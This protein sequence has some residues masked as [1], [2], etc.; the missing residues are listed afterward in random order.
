M[1]LT[2]ETYYNIAEKRDRLRGIYDEYG[3]NAVFIVPAGL[4]KDALLDLICGGTPYFGER[5]LVWTV[6][7]LYK[8]LTRSS[9]SRL[10]VI[11]PPDH[12]LILRWLLDGFLAEMGELGVKL[13]PGVYHKGFVSVLGDNIKDLLAEEVSSGKLSA[14]LFEEGEADPALP[15][16]ILISLYERYTDYLEE[17]GLAD[18][19]QLPTLAR[20]AIDSARALDFIKDKKIVLAG[21][22]SFTGAQLKLARALS[23]A[24]EVLMLQPETGLDDFHDGIKQLETEY[25]ERP[26][27]D[28]PVV[29]LEASNAHL[30]LEMLARDVALWINGEGGLTALGALDDYGDVGLLTLP[31]RLPVME[32]ALSR[33]KIPYNVR[34]RGTVRETPAGELPAMI[35]RAWSS[36][37]DYYNTSILLADPLLFD[38][39]EEGAELYKAD[40]FPEGYEA[41]RRA[42][43]PRA[44]GR[45]AD[46]RELCRSFERGG[47]PVEI[48]AFWRDFLKKA[49][50]VE[51]AARTAGGEASLD[52]MVRNISHALFELEKKI[53]ILSD[54]AKH[55]GPASGAALR[56]AEAV[57]FVSDWGETATLP[58][59][60][61]QSHSLTLYAGMPPILTSHRFWLM[62]DIDYNSWPGMLRESLLLRNENKV[63]FNAG[64]GE[65]GERP[66]LPE[67]REERE[68]KE[69]VFR[70]LLATGRDGV[71]IARSLTDSSKDPVGESQFVT[72][73]F[74][75][76]EARRCW[77]SVGELRYPLEESLP[78]GGEPWFPSAE[79][80]CTPVS[81]GKQ[82]KI[83]EGRG[84]AAEK[85]VVRISDIDTWLA[86]P[87][88]YWCR[89]SLRFDKPRS[90]LYDPRTAG[91]LTHYVW[92]ESLRAKSAEPQLSIQRYVM[93]NWWRFKDER[94][95]ALDA[96]PRLARHEK[97]LMRQIFE[98]AAMQD[99]IE[100]R[101][102][103]EA[104]LSL[105]TENSLDVFEVDG[106]V[107][108][109]QADR[110]DRYRDGCVVI[111]YKLGRSEN[112]D[113][114]LQVP[115]YGAI[116]RAAGEDVGGVAWFGHADCSVSGYFCD[117]Y[118][119]IYGTAATKRS[120]TTLGEKLDE[121]L[122]AM[123]AMAASVKNGIYR[124]K[125]DV[126][127][128]K[129]INC[130]FYVLCRKRENQ[131]Y[132]AVEDEED[133]SDE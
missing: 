121:A 31:D 21:F 119:G 108:S 65:G 125:Y 63:K 2:V 78:D 58:I 36:N 14:A 71:V 53:K 24:A 116:L 23:D 98:M 103:P 51:R 83:P 39:G 115:A 88:L 117:P 62:T 96:D 4:D 82:H 29:R 38:C 95:P 77:R 8:E 84:E 15:E 26:E 3:E 28:I 114:E 22:L 133:G 130:A 90:E 32:Y 101:I 49:G 7:D 118:F 128:P 120:K 47:T 34:V 35:W 46:L 87:Y 40:S 127:D 42:L 100:A 124:P 13:A 85:P 9:A 59:Q 10:R 76:K 111:D 69:A 45:F 50:V 110:I 25:K 52:E 99:D 86:C 33:Y 106:V 30:E 55:I 1:P 54:D 102:P 18:A 56:G 107:F 126:K 81:S 16:S 12:N 6:G 92:E 74:A 91:T 94:Y 41:W 66:H 67:L 75:E 72:S 37:W 112:H 11:D 44:R 123:A 80:I 131:G 104:R 73:I 68:Q 105:V 109:G 20:K 97:R 89:R 5:P 61:P 43:A 70:R 122:E 79:V 19:A 57:A 64:S 48:L 132:S 17:Y 129:C 93:E 60:L 27:W 113:K